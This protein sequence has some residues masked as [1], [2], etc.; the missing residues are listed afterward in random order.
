MTVVV[1]EFVADARAVDLAEVAVMCGVS[2]KGK[3]DE[4]KGPCPRCGGKDRFSINYKKG[5]WN[6][7]HLGG[8]GG[9]G[10]ALVA[11]C[12]DFDLRRRSD[13]LAACAQIL[14]KDVPDE[15][16]RESDEDRQAR[17][18]RLVALKAKA[19]REAANRA[20]ESNAFR[21]RA[22]QKAQAL[23]G[24]AGGG[25]GTAVADYLRLRTG[26]RIPDR[27]FDN[28]RFAARYGYWHGRDERGHAMECHVGPAMIAPFIDRG[29][30]VTGCHETWID[31][32]R[33]PKFRPHLGVDENGV[34]LV[35]KKMQG[36][37]K[38][39]I[40]PILGD[41]SAE[42][43]VG[44]EGIENVL[45]VA[46]G[47]GFRPDT[48]YFS[49]GS[50][51][52]L[53]GPAD[54]GSNFDHPTQTKVGQNGRIYPVRVPGIEPRPDSDDDAVFV[55]DHVTVLVLVCDGD[56]EPIKTAADITRAMRRFAR[57]GRVILD[58]WPP[59][60]RDWSSVILEGLLKMGRAA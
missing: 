30:I 31:L 14:G 20:Q 44:G 1:D 54:A 28:L 56:S 50:L 40:I 19:Q 23:Y 51:G 34:V 46:G 8:A 6:C 22:I 12:F 53:C 5:L 27:V 26:F 41:Q 49:A 21:E 18:E 52:N 39:S 45:A 11:H 7:G 9:D 37:V 59:R 43:W 33:G 38:G 32:A 55:A 60:G 10:L 47:E 15:A 48:F 17:T 57:D 25:G 3:A 13:L 58:W 2:A 16:D 42:R 4:K 29:G 36:S 35:T 24:R